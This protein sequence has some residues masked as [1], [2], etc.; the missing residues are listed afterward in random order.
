MHQAKANLHFNKGWLK[1]LALQRT[2]K[3]LHTEMLHFS[4]KSVLCQDYLDKYGYQWHTE[5]VAKQ[6]L[7]RETHHRTLMLALMKK[8]KGLIMKPYI[9]LKRLCSL[10]FQAELSR[11]PG[12]GTLHTQCSLMQASFFQDK[13]F[14]VQCSGPQNSCEIHISQKLLFISYEFVCKLVRREETL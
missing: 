9:S 14:P 6:L 12:P 4:K 5:I 10:W 7:I 11:S 3:P 1:S 2:R 13:Y 8:C